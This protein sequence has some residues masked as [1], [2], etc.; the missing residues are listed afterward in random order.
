MLAGPDYIFHWPLQLLWVG[1]LSPLNQ[2]SSTRQTDMLHQTHLEH[3]L[4]CECH[5]L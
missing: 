4:R 2:N 5:M 3:V 1:Y